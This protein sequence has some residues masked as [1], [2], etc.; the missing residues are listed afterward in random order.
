MKLIKN[1]FLSGAS[2]DEIVKKVGVSKSTIYIYVKEMGIREKSFRQKCRD[3]GVNY[4][5]VNTAMRRYGISM[6][7]AINHCKTH[8]KVKFVYQGIEGLPKIAKKLDLNYNSLM[9]VVYRLGVTNI[10]DAVEITKSRKKGNNKKP[11]IKPEVKTKTKPVKLDSLW[12]IA[13][14]ITA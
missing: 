10:K 6:E 8:R 7:E 9:H 11:K 14:G 1:L 2:T 4:E 12:K 13:L 5:S 3:S